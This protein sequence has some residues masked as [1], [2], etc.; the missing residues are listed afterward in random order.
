M[1]RHQS[2]RRGG[3]ALHVAPLFHLAALAAWNN[4]CVMGGSHVFLR[5]VADVI[6]LLFE[7]Y[8]NGKRVH[9]SSSLARISR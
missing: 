4:Q 8:K 1:S 9:V 5:N 2:S 3:R 7:I 6:N